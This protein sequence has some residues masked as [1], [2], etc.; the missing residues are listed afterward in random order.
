MEGSK[1]TI[2]L[3]PNDWENIERKRGKELTWGQGGERCSESL[4]VDFDTLLAIH[5]VT[6]YRHLGMQI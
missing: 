4:D 3:K 5:T 2:I 1:P 6:D